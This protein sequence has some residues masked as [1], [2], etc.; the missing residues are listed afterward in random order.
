MD[1]L[2]NIN[3]PCV[4]SQSATRGCAILEKG[5]KPRKKNRNIKENKAPKTLAK[6]KESSE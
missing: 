6:Q 5:S 3:L 4:L 2:K 1:R